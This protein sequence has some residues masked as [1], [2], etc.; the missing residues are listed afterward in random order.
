MARLHKGSSCSYLG[1]SVLRAVGKGSYSILLLDYLFQR[2]EINL[3][4]NQ[5]ASLPG[6]GGNFAPDYAAYE[7]DF[8]K[9]APAGIVP[10]IRSVWNSL[11]AQLAREY[12]LAIQWLLDCGLANRVDRITKP[13][14]PLSAY[15]DSAAYK[16]YALDVGL[17]CAIVMGYPLF[18]HPWLVAPGPPARG[19]EW[20]AEPPEQLIIF[21]SPL[22][23]LEDSDTKFIQKE[24]CT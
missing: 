16:L 9:H 12:E 10:R 8:S 20:R 4:E 19:G 11:P 14:I 13:G 6:I 1:R 2:V 22:L 18:L 24:I 21:W 3:R 23:D 7:H 15:H 17:L 5:E